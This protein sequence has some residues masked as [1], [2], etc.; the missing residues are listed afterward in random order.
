M[1][2]AAT[3]CG[4]CHA[5]DV[6]GDGEE[7]CPPECHLLDLNTRAGWI[8]GADGGTAPIL[9]ES[10]VGATDYDWSHAK[11]RQRLRNNRMPPG[12]PFNI[13]EANRD[14]GDV[15]LAGAADANDILLGGQFAVS[16]DGTA[17]GFGEVTYGGCKPRRW[18]P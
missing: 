16:V 14:G 17:A 4:A 6:D 10:S 9:G 11:L 15:I 13:D 5:G 3:A 8:A 2:V 7:V 1:V 18:P 12:I